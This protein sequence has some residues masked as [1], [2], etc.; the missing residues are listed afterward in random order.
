M[1]MEHRLARRMDGVA[2]SATLALAE[3]A[4]QM[5]A[6]GLDV[7]SL[8]AGEPDRAPAPP[9]IEALC[10]AAHA[11]QTRYTAVSGIEPLRRAIAEDLRARSGIEY[12]LGQIVVSTGAK[13]AI[14]NALQALLDP[15]DEV[16]FA[17]PYWLSYRDMSLLAGGVPV[18]VET[19]FEDGFLLRPEALDRSLG[20]KAKVLILN[21][22][23][24]PSGGAFRRAELEGLA[25]VLRAH[26][27]VYVI[28]DEIYRRFVYEPDAD[29]SLLQVAPDLA[30]RTIVIDGCSKTYAMTGLRVGWAAG[31]K[32]VIAAMS[33]LQGQSTS[34][35]CSTSQHAAVA[36]LTGSQDWVQEMVTTFDVRRRGV[37]EALAKIPGLRSLLPRGAFY[38]FPDVSALVGRVTAKGR[39]IADGTSFAEYLL[40]E[41]LLTVVPGAPFGAPNHIRLSYATDMATIDAGL[42]RLDSA[43]RA[44]A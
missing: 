19:S 7:L 13:Q 23:N 25:A 41:H 14:Y 42:A 24:N 33:I 30:E 35:P 29:G 3:R 40:E 43:V 20:P 1:S 4:K 27:G 16:A 38:A 36:A 22:P 28:A 34:N 44:L 37:T 12:E 15:G 31:P 17:A 10:A 21:S 26:P 39:R 5:Q 18:V 2:P 9:I 11:G 6:R 8:T 32:P